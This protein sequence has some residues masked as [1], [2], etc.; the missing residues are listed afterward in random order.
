V[1]LRTQRWSYVDYE[2]SA[3]ELYDMARDPFQLENL[4]GRSQLKE[5]RDRLRSRLAA[6]EDCEGPTCR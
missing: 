6:L 1:G 3:P 2:T 5:V 4:A